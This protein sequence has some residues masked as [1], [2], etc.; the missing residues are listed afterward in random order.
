MLRWADFQGNRFPF[1]ADGSP[2]RDV[3]RSLRVFAFNRAF[4][5]Q[6]FSPQISVVHGGRS[7]TAQLCD[8]DRVFGELS[9]VRLF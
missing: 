6:G 5:L 8:Y 2:R 7:S 9:F 3:A 1:T 4:T